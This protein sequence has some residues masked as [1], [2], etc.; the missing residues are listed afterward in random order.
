VICHLGMGESQVVVEDQDGTLLGRKSPETPLEL[1]PIVHG[2]DLVGGIGVLALH[3]EDARQRT[4]SPL[5][6]DIAAADE[7]PMQ[8]RLEARR[9]SQAGELTPG[10]D[11]GR[12]DRVLG[13]AGVAKDPKRDR[14]APVAKFLRQGTEGLSV[15]MP[16]AFDDWC[17]HLAPPQGASIDAP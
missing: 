14:H 11:E 16:R 5:R 6:L 9:I 2:Q 7:N 1:I 13:E 10:L 17:E 12:L 15:P 8:P 4:S 3:G